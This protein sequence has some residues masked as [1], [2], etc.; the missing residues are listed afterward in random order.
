MPTAYVSTSPGLEF[1]KPTQPF[2]IFGWIA[3]GV[4]NPAGWFYYL[5]WGMSEFNYTI[6]AWHVAVPL[7]LGL[8]FA[9]MFIRDGGL[10][11]RG[12]MGITLI[13]IFAACTGTAP[14]YTLITWAAQQVGISVSAMGLF[15]VYSWDAAIAHTGAYVRASLYFSG[16]AAIPA[17]I[18]LRI[19]SLQPA[20]RRRTPTAKPSTPPQVPG[21]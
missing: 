14:F 18:I 3:A 8:L 9:M 16:V 17:V 15:E 13:C 10:G 20:P 21:A 7:E 6:W 2:A 4:L 12:V 5:P 11:N 19:I 1:R